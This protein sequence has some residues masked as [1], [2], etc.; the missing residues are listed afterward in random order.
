MAVASLG[1]C[2]LVLHADMPVRHRPTCLHQVCRQ[3]LS[4]STSR[5]CPS[6][7]CL[8]STSTRAR[9]SAVQ[10]MHVLSRHRGHPS[11]HLRTGIGSVARVLH[12]L[13]RSGTACHVPATVW[14]DLA[15]R[16]APKVS[17]PRKIADL[18]KACSV[19][20]YHGAFPRTEQTEAWSVQRAS[21]T[22]GTSQILGRRTQMVQSYAPSK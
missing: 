7:L 13:A 21:H 1:L 19:R 15:R 17:L 4:W 11:C 2:I 3:Q 8:P 9:S 12:C 14:H 20:G 16:P 18:K 5:L 10:H 6:W 22:R